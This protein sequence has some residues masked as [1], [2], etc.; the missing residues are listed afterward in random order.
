MKSNSDE[1]SSLSW[2]PAGV[3]R[4]ALERL[5]VGAPLRAS[6][7]PPRAIERGARVDRGWPARRISGDAL[8]LPRRRPPR[9][10]APE[11][12][13]GHRLERTIQSDVSTRPLYLL[14]PEPRLREAGVGPDAAL[15]AAERFVGPRPVYLLDLDYGRRDL[16]QIEGTGQEEG[17]A[18]A[19]AFGS[20]LEAV[21]R[22][23]ESGARLI[24][25]GLPIGDPASVLE[26]EGWKRLLR[27]AQ[28]ENARV[29]AYLPASSLDSSL[30]DRA[31]AALLLVA[32]EDETRFARSLP[33][34]LSVVGSIAP[35]YPI[36]DLPEP[37]VEPEPE[38]EREAADTSA[39]AAESDV[40]AAV[41]MRV[42]AEEV[43]EEPPRAPPIE[44]PAE[45]PT[46]PAEPDMRAPTARGLTLVEWLDQEEETL[47]ELERRRPYMPPE[48]RKPDLP[49]S[50]TE[51]AAEAVEAE[52]EE[53]RSD[54]P[55]APATE[56]E[57]TA[58]AGAFA[59]ALEERV[60][61]AP[62][63]RLAIPTRES[64][65]DLEQRYSVPQV[66]R[67]MERFIRV[68]SIV[69]LAYWTY[70]IVWRWTASLN[71]DAL[72]F[73]IP[74][75]LAET[76]GWVT[77][78]FLVFTVWR[79]NHRI[80]PP[81]PDELAVDVFITTYDE[82]LEVIRRTTISA[83]EMRYPHRTYVLDDGRR[84]EVR[85]MARDL[86]VGYITR[87]N[88]D[89]AKAGNLNNALKH[90]SGD[91]IL[92][93]DADHA[94][95][96]HML[97]RLLGFFTDEKVAFVQTPQD[98]YNMDSFT[99]HVDEETQRVWEEQKLFFSV[100]QPGKDSWNSAFFCGSC[101]I[102]RRKALDDI[103]GFSVSSITEDVETSMKIHARGWKSVYYGESLAY[104]LAAGS[105]A[106]FH[107][108]QGRW[109]Q[110][111][112]QIL[113]GLNPLTYPGLT[114]AQRIGY[115]YSLSS[116]A[117]G[118]QKLIFYGAPLIFL[119]TGVL[120][121]QAVDSAF[122]SRFIPYLVLSICLY[123]MLARGLGFTWIAERYQMAKFW[124]YT[125][126][127]P[128]YLTRKRLGFRVTPKGD[129]EVPFR[130]YAPHIALMVISVIAV[131]WGT[132][133]YEYGWIRYPVDGWRSLAFQANFVWALLNFVL[134]AY[135]VRLSVRLH[136]HRQDHRFS[137]RFPIYLRPRNRAGEL[138]EEQL[139]LTEDLNTH[140]LSFRSVT[141]FKEG[142]G[143]R[144]RLPLSTREITLDGT[145][146][147][148]RREA[149][150]GVPAHIH[151]VEFKDVPLEIR[152]AIEIHI[153]HHAV[154][155]KK[156]QYSPATSIVVGRG[157]RREKRRTV[158]LPTWVLLGG[159]TQKERRQNVAF[160][161]ELGEGGGSLIMNDPIPPD[162]PLVFEVPG[163]SIR[164]DGR[165]TFSHAMETPIGVRFVV[166]IRTDA[167][168]SSEAP[169]GLRSIFGGARTAAK[170]VILAL[171]LTA[172]VAGASDAQLV[173]YGSAEAD[174]RDQAV[175]LLGADMQP[176]DADNGPIG[177]LMAYRLWFA[178][179]GGTRTIDAAYPSVG[180][181]VNSG[182]T[183][184]QAGI[185]Y[186][187]L[188]S[189]EPA[190]LGAPGGGREGVMLNAT[191]STR[192]APIRAEV[193]GSYNFGD[194][195]LWIRGRGSRP[196]GIAWYAGAAFL[197][198]EVIYQGGGVDSDFHAFQIAP[199]LQA[200]LTTNLVGTL[201]AGWKTDD[202]PRTRGGGFPYLR[203]EF[204]YLPR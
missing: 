192:F 131:Y 201:A 164:G 129:S 7:P 149:D 177:S 120:P 121:I 157:E 73:S 96:P 14:I 183:R 48:R 78:C 29:L 1:P 81:T 50:L 13:I 20:S 182:G 51:P 59:A 84:P 204:S 186:L 57:P 28:R 173:A 52:E 203:L 36:P 10:A 143:L 152:D 113:R 72:W 160:L 67:R 187:F 76:W 125:R 106:A 197:G 86:G 5:A 148:V 112:M 60:Q 115:F 184:L 18:E 138:G 176:M 32:P 133:A 74:L 8:S 198:A 15:R 24:P 99:S 165:T 118:L 90:T 119:F 66:S 137:D 109:A 122:L 92:Q 116:F 104:G 180:Y 156:L 38:L 17:I 114:M 93:L 30:V 139:A 80:P 54:R 26:D 185:G 175:L 25:F 111:S 174:S 108:Q 77:A 101:A 124:T 91:F 100:L 42:E 153:A 89:H 107:V 49:P 21:S 62:R 144:M 16:S 159:D 145:V 130:T 61:K 71:L 83:R 128:T 63:E 110:G 117:V 68:A 154:P 39:E 37:A 169:R 199:Y 166:G 40:D 135:V 142:T 132:F 146:M 150:Q 9:P 190:A 178:G 47:R 170:S 195:Y 31:G 95:L 179:E 158:R 151:G 191:A 64:V 45:E 181:F 34:D 168:P 41:D 162:T 123:E 85:T 103:G 33:G 134:A 141:E 200:P 19:L 6:G 126:A 23:L 56:G 147:H 171:G 105:A 70:Y 98:F 11:I 88:N 27:Q 12:A 167:G 69:I 4:R 53:D 35:P 202:L 44:P 22:P 193:G 43:A 140:G 161:E 163:T 102:L 136:H 189:P 97:D 46:P 2:G 196:L 188:G 3:D 75:V 82:P 79:L 194:Q 58:P 87:K 65:S 127:L 94:P 172:G 155:F 55:A